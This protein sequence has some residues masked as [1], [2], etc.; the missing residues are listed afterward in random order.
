MAT[1]IPAVTARTVFNPPR[2][3]ITCAIALSTFSIA[4][5]N[6]TIL[7]TKSELIRVTDNSWN[8]AWNSAI[9]PLI[10]SRYFSF[11]AKA[12]PA[13]FAES[14]TT[15]SAKS[16]FSISAA[17]TFELRFPPII[18]RILACEISVNSSH[19]SESSLMI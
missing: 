6:S 1:T 13:A 19:T 5:P 11:S 4:V 7:F 8:V 14:S 2:A 9:L 16:K 18:S 12:E 15:L 3:S 17:T 10:L